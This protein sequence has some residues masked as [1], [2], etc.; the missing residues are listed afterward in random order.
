MI[1]EYISYDILHNLAENLM[2]HLQFK[3]SIVGQ[4]ILIF[5]PNLTTAKNRYDTKMISII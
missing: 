5:T 2:H 3:H 1:C 4:I